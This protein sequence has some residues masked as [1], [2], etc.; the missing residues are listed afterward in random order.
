MAS[1]RALFG[2]NLNGVIS[3]ENILQDSK[4]SLKVLNNKNIHIFD[5]SY[6]MPS[7]GRNGEKE[8]LSNPR[9]PGA[10]FWNIDTIATKTQDNLPHMLPSPRDWKAA[11]SS[12]G[13]KYYDSI[14]AY[15]SIG[16]FSSPRLW[17]QFKAYQHGGEVVILNGGL[18]KWNKLGGKLESG[19]ITPAKEFNEAL[20]YTVNK[21][22]VADLQEIIQISK[23]QTDT[24]KSPYLLLDARSPNR[25]YGREPEPRAGLSS[26]HI[27]G[28]INL[29][30]ADL[31]KEGELLAPKEL[32][33]VLQAKKLLDNDAVKIF[34]SCGSGITAC[35]V[36]LA[37]YTLRLKPIKVYD[38]SWAE[39]GQTS[40]TFPISKED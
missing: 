38:G 10:K 31:V 22:W 14:I 7:S 18:P 21:D 6:H 28:A 37:Y 23:V 26:G 33:E 40:K 12:F 5:V 20:H 1:L 17:W 2:N 27:P 8:F 25:F 9:I 30:F 15:D 39:Y 29:P 16:C 24:A 35:I 19:A 11:L 32:K 4:T 36:A 13:I 34:T 3:V